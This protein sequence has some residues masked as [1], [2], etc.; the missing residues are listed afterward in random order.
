[1]VRTLDLSNHYFDI[2]GKWLFFQTC[3]SWLYVTQTRPR[4]LLV[5]LFVTLERIITPLRFVNNFTLSMS[6]CSA[7][8]IDWLVLPF[9]ILFCW[10][11]P[12]SIIYH[13]KMGS[14]I[15]CIPVLHKVCFWYLTSQKV[16]F[17]VN[18]TH[19]L[20]SFMQFNKIYYQFL[21]FTSEKVFEYDLPPV[22]LCAIS[23]W[24]TCMRLPFGSSLSI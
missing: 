6:V 20:S 24:L 3:D 22:C 14:H 21:A 7:L 19:S 23:F 17:A 2:F 1:M 9:V 5:F 10:F 16:T 8:V 13:E 11:V 18:T 4:R 12:N 15:C